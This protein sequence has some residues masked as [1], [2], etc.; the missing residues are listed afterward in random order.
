MAHPLQ[1]LAAAI[2]VQMSVIALFNEKL[3][4]SSVAFKACC[5]ASGK[6]QKEDVFIWCYQMGMQR[7]L[8]S[9]QPLNDLPCQISNL[10]LSENRSH[11]YL[12][13]TCIMAQS[14]E[15]AWRHTLNSFIN[16]YLYIVV[17]QPWAAT[18]YSLKRHFH[19]CPGLFIL[20]HFLQDY[21][22]QPQTKLS[23]H[24]I[25][26]KMEKGHRNKCLIT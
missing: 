8:T 17:I 5:P 11:P 7:E 4:D 13:I 21:K 3:V 15:D 10:S 24:R 6:S 18:E 20:N 22:L 9:S 19:H 1:H 23:R 12:H 14:Q 16:R 26:K 25:L 2:V